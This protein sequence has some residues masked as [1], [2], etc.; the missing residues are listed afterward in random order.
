[1]R[2]TQRTD[3]ALRALIYLVDAGEVGATPQEIAEA[4]DISLTHMR[5][6]MRAL[7]QEGFVD[8]GRGRGRRTRLAPGT[9][10]VGDV[11]RALE[12]LVLV[13][14]FGEQSACALGGACRLQ[15]A[16]GQAQAAFLAT[17]DEVPITELANRRSQGLLRVL[18]A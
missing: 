9:F 10:S 8:T 12:P 7:S 14:C 1:M 4:H 15:K 17:L 13:E 2:L 6:V 16:L 3:Y 18:R 5:K 11:V